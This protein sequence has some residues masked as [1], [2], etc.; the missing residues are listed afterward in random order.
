MTS[1][2]EETELCFVG[3]D[4]GVH[5]A[6]AVLRR[7]RTV[8]LCEDFPINKTPK[9]V[10]YVKRKYKTTGKKVS[11]KIQGYKREF[12][13]KGTADLFDQVVMLSGKKLAVLEA[14]TAMPRDST[15]AAFTF[16]GSLWA[17][18]MALADRSISYEMVKPKDW[19]AVMLSGVAHNDPKARRQA[20]LEK[21]RKMFPT[22]DLSLVKHAEKAAALLLAEYCRRA[23]VHNIATLSASQEDDNDS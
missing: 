7:D 14:V 10:K 17:L 19:Q 21:A 1:S 4:P 5:G 11:V 15:T 22:V 16:G 13:F 8:L 18:Q 23:F 20:Y 6:V 12:D 3:I 2:L 9:A